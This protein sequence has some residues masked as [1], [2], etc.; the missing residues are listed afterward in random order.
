M[1]LNLGELC[2]TEHECR[3]TSID[4]RAPAVYGYIRFLCKQHGPSERGQLQDTKTF[5]LL[6]KLLLYETRYFRTTD[7]RDNIY[8]VLPIASNA[9]GARYP[10]TDL[11]RPDYR[12]PVRKIIFN[13]TREIAT[14]TGS[15]SVLSLIDHDSKQIPDLPSWVPDYSASSIQALAYICKAELYSAFNR[16]RRSPE[17][18]IVDDVFFLCAV[19]W[20]AIA[21]IEL[22]G[23]PF[24]LQG[25]M[26][27]CLQ[28]PKIYFNGQTRVEALWRTLI[29]DTDGE[30]SL[31][32][33]AIGSSFRQYVLLVVATRVCE[34]LE[35]WDGRELEMPDFVGLMKLN[36]NYDARPDP[37]LPRGEEVEFFWNMFQTMRRSPQ[38]NK[39]L[40][41]ELGQGGYLY[42]A[43]IESVGAAGN[44]SRQ[45]GISLVCSSLCRARRY[46][47]VF[48]RLK[49]AIRPAPLWWRAVQVH[50]GGLPV[51]V[52]AW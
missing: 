28:L 1:D 8:A 4:S 5:N 17:L 22:P 15:T 9:F 33:E 35:S 25:K 45:T 23:G 31:A 50:W 10:T 18:T 39:R 32:P 38:E 40:L 11:I 48:S 37:W 49:S 13:V 29:A 21:E 19:R 20:D 16:A 51:W 14:K 24:A 43:A 7:P 6:L 34:I 12:L 36:N 44:F 46:Y 47:L 2:Q 27:L 41:E 26:D 3:E 42:T 30:Q 52:H